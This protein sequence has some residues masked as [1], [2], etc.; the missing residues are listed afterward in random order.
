MRSKEAGRQFCI[1]Y[2]VND[3]WPE[4]KYDFEWLLAKFWPIPGWSDNWKET[5]LKDKETDFSKIKK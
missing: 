1:D 5:I 4:R 2:W 3:K